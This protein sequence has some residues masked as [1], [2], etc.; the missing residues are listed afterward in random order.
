MT[1]TAGAFMVANATPAWAQTAGENGPAMTGVGGFTGGEGHTSHTP[2]N[3]ANP[4]V[5]GDGI[6]DNNA[7]TPTPQPADEATYSIRY[8]VPAGAMNAPLTLI[9]GIW[10]MKEP[11]LGI[12]TVW[13]SFD[14]NKTVGD[15][16]TTITTITPDKEHATH[17]SEGNIFTG[18]TTT[19]ITPYTGEKDGVKFRAYVKTTNTTPAVTV[20]KHEFT[21]DGNGYTATADDVSLN[22]KNI[23][24]LTTIT[25]SNGKEI[26]ITWEK[27]VTTVD[28]DGAKFITLKGV[29][30]TMLDN[31]PVTVHITA[32]RAEDTTIRALNIL[33]T[34]AEGQTTTTTLDTFNPATH[35]YTITMPHT[36]TVDK[37]TLSAQGGV[38]MHVGD[39]K[40]SLGD[41]TS[42]ILTLPIN[43]VTYTV[44]VKF[45]PAPLDNTNESASLSGIYVN[46][47][48]QNIKGDLIDKWDKNRLDYTITISKDAPSPYILPDFD[49]NKVNVTPSDVEA[50][51]QAVKQAWVVENKSDH[52]KRTYTVTV[53]REKTPSADELFKPVKTDPQKA[54][55]DTTDTHDTSL[56]DHGWVDKAGKYHSVKDT[57]YII[58][59]GGSFSYTAK[60]GQVTNQSV[61]K[62]KG[63]TYE[64]TVN[65]L[66][67]DG[68][69]FNQHV[70]TVT[71]MS[72]P[73]HRAEL[74]DIKVN[75]K[76]V[77]NFNKGAYAYTVSVGNLDKWTISPIWDKITGMSVN[78]DKQGTKATITVTSA[79]GL[80]KTVYTVNV[81]QAMVNT[82]GTVGVAL[83]QTGSDTSLLALIAGVSTLVAGL[84][85][86]G[87]H[88]LARQHKKHTPDESNDTPTL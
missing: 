11:L 17:T 34:N 39:F 19:T 13:D 6:V 26:P 25:L 40:G 16:I 41:D 76:S 43:N 84:I 45:A 46:K 79:D 18:I 71:Y 5:N 53:V 23:P 64:Y 61:K 85:I 54:T 14:V 9:D 65:T 27:N 30:S 35:E 3:V 80:V 36:A 72:E 20:D 68:Y 60:K 22:D 31:T 83:A 69:T 82:N 12:D 42:R 29:A 62:I 10:Q 63:M 49:T 4:D 70:F 66:A 52:T 47:T 21:T 55:V 15:N 88:M 81:V 24:S 57:T 58:P 50:T 33:S 87:A 48:G 7:P 78:I 28:K 75:G 56:V 32:K 73:T 8:S 51:D 37:F 67:P 2:D 38:D 59:E 1:P 86:G 44:N 77:D 74:T